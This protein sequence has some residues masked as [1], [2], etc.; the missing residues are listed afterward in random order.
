MSAED[1]AFLERLDNAK[2][3]FRQSCALQAA[4]IA[5]MEL[6]VEE[7]VEAQKHLFD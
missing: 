6:S 3:E 7:S 1:K 5:D 2:E 4:E